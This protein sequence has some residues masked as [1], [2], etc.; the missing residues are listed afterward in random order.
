MIHVKTIRRKIKEVENYP[1]YFIDLHG[2]VY[3]K[4]IKGFKIIKNQIAKN[5]Y[6]RAELWKEDKG[7]KFLVHRLVAQA[8]IKNEN[9]YPQV[10]H[11]DGDK[12]NNYYKNLEW[13]TRSKNQKHAYETGLQKGYCKPGNKLSEEH[14]LKLREGYRNYIKTLKGK[15]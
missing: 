10:N 15:I 8:F 1:N 9:N 3:V 4:R 5:G 2:T 11:K 12:A 14:K 13:T 6:V 7:K